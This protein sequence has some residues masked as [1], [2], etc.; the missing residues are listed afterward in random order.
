MYAY[1]SSLCSRL[2]G[3]AS[4]EQAVLGRL[5]SIDSTLRELT[6]RQGAQ[7]AKQMEISDIVSKA[8]DRIESTLGSLLH[9]GERQ[10]AEID[11]LIAQAKSTEDTQQAAVL[12]LKGFADKVASMSQAAT[13][14][15]TLKSQIATLT[16]ELKAKNDELAAAIVTPPPD[17]PN[18]PIPQTGPGQ[19]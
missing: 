3:T 6:S 10:M 19:T 15:A 14:L 18:A 7:G 17:T 1:L 13:D 12:V 2:F 8:N 9:Q 5:D 16:G 11:D 4:F